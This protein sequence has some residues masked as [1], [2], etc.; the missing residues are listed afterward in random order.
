M[1]PKVLGVL[2][3]IACFTYLAHLPF[4]FLWPEAGTMLT[5][6]VAIPTT[7][8][9][10]WMVLYRL[11]RGLKAPGQNAEVP[12]RHEQCRRLGDKTGCPAGPGANRPDRARLL[13]TCPLLRMP[14]HGGLS[15]RSNVECRSSAPGVPEKVTSIRKTAREP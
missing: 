1:L 14:R 11:I 2:L 15:A 7:L 9:E 10:A 5:P 12:H 3:I 4:A 6:F 8:A 13:E